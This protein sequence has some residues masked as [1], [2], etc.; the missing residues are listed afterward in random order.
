VHAFPGCAAVVYGHTHQPEL[1]RH[2]GVWILNPGSPTERRR[3][4]HRSLIALEVDVAEVSP[5]LVML[6]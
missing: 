3:A 1:T 6:D 2:G 5:R 4:P